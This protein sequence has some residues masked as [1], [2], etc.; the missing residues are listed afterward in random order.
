[1]KRLF[2]TTKNIEDAHAISDE[3]H[4]LGIDDHHFYIVSKDEGGIQSHQLHGSKDLEKTQILAAKKRTNIFA[5]LLTL[6]IGLAIG[7]GTKLVFNNPL[8]FVIL[9]IAIFAVL[10][11]LVSIACNSFDSYFNGVFE[12]HLDRGETLIVIDV[13]G[14]QVNKVEAQLDKHPLASFIADSSSIASPLPQ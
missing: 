9:C 8:G 4:E 5:S 2:Y 7:F 1:M 10:R 11:M 13:Q 3:V 6:A 12:D 14:E